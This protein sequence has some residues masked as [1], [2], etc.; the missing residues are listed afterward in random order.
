LSDR[1]TLFASGL[2][3][4]H[5]VFDEKVAAVFPDMINRSVPGYATIIAM[6]GTLSAEYAQPASICYDLGCSLGAASL[7]MRHNIRAENCAIVAV[8][9]SAAMV[10]GCRQAIERDS[11]LLPVAV[12]FE[13]ILD[14]P[15]NNA[16]MV[17]MNFTLQFVKPEA[18]DE[19]LTRIY[20]G[21]L[22]GGM[23]ILSEKILF[24]DSALNDLFIEMYHRFKEQQGYSKLEISR[25][26]AA[27]EKVLIPETIA[28]HE[29]RLKKAGF[30]T[31]D[32]WFQCFNFASIVAVKS[33]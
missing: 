6:I 33:H 20:E 4:E 14:T 10:E 24:E 29:S 15:V 25:K 16:S 12:R 11:A 8:D 27:L 1:D 28:A 32:V 7:S 31:F 19:L 26:R 17:V 5:F 21:L 23:L 30:E 2:P 13:D 9:N 22:P 18:R 3:N